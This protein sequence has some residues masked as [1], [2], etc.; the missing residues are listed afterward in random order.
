M[1]DMCI[2][3]SARGRVGCGGCPEVQGVGAT[4]R[5]AFP[6]FPLGCDI[7]R[8]CGVVLDPAFV[9]RGE[10]PPVC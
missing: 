6:R 1:F 8:G 10:G 9:Q 2:C 4:R 5:E 7:W 3:Q